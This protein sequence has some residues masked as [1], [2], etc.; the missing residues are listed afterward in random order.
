MVRKL[1]DQVMDRLKWTGSEWRGDP[2]R[3]AL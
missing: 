1:S 3:T 2:P